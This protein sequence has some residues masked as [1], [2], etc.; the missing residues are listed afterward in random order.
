MIPNTDYVVVGSGLTGA[1]VAHCLRA[2]NREVV[3]IEKRDHIAGLCYDKIHKPS[4]Y[5]YHVHGPHAFRTQSTVMWN[6]L[7]SLVKFY[8]FKLRIKTLIDEEFLVWPPSRAIIKEMCEGQANSTFTGIPANFE[9][10]SLS[11]MPY[12]VY[13]KFVKPYTEKQ[14]G[15]PA[16]KLWVGLSG[17][18]QVRD[19]DADINLFSHRYQGLPMTG[20]TGLVEALIK[21]IPVIFNYDF[22]YKENQT[23]FNK[24]LVY[25]GAIDEFFEYKLGQ[26]GYRGMS[27]ETKYYE[28]GAKH[29]HTV[30]IYNFPSSNPKY[31]RSIDWEHWQSPETSHENTKDKALI[32]YGFP[33]KPTSSDEFAYPILIKKNTDLLEK[34]QNYAK[35]KNSSVVFCGRLAD[36]RYY[37]MNHAIARGLG[38]AQEILQE[39]YKGPILADG[40]I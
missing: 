30:P 27:H 4:G 25:T 14:W 28:D 34:Y 20:F 31:I 5:R 7:N 9:E 40:K 1:V 3:I 17:R 19:D 23:C 10:A 26:L 15:I 6:W 29:K 11:K 33:K 13:S 35:E 38:I 22:K 12:K 39:D 36:F 8:P 18:F 21:D 37:D 32:S 24:K 16:N 2:A